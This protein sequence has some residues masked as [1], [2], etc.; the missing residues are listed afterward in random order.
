[1]AGKGSSR[2]PTNFD[3]YSAGYDRIFNTGEIDMEYNKMPQRKE[4]K[5]KKKQK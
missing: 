1:M 3:A 4:K 5:K 2:R